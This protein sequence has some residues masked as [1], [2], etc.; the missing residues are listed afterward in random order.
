MM[1]TDSEEEK[2]LPTEIN[3]VHFDVPELIVNKIVPTASKKYINN[4]VIYAA[5][6]SNDTGCYEE[7]FEGLNAKFVLNR[8]L[9]LREWTTDDDKHWR[10]KISNKP[11]SKME[12]K[13]LGEKLDT[14][15]KTYEAKVVG[16]CPIK[17]ELYSQCFSEFDSF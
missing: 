10:Q 4:Y 13:E 11:V 12:S 14:Y 7:I 17:R 1:N 6:S 15:L 9:P 2:K 8:I 16:I 3:L 5:N